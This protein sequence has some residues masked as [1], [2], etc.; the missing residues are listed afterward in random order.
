MAVFTKNIAILVFHLDGKLLGCEQR[1]R[2][3]HDLRQLRRLQPMVDVVRHPDLQNA[4]V[5]GAVR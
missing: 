1:P 2:E 3:L 5:C 4:R